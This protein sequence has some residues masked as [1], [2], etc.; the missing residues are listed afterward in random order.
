MYILIISQETQQNSKY[1]NKGQIT[2][3][4]I[5]LSFVIDIV[6]PG[7]ILGIVMMGCAGEG[8]E[9]ELSFF[10]YIIYVE[11]WTVL[12]HEYKYK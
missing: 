4:D 5:T 3:D 8:W 12:L 6:S 2:F 9:P 1:L 7:S 10:H 11:Y